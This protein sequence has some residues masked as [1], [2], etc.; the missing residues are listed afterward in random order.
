M[1][2]SFESLTRAEKVCYYNSMEENTLLINKK[3]GQNI[4]LYRK[5]SGLTQA[6]LAEKINYSDKSVSKWES[7]GGAPDIYVLMQLAEIFDVTVNDL[8]ASEQPKHVR[9]K[10]NLGLHLLIMGLSSGIVWLV[11]TFIFVILNMLPA[12]NGAVWTSF[13]F[14]L[15]VNS[16]TLLVLVSAWKYKRLNFVFVTATIW[17]SLLAVFCV[18][19]YIVGWAGTA[20]LVFLLGIPLQILEIFWAFF[21]YSL[22]KRKNKQ[23]KKE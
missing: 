18:L 23:D 2:N 22:F 17:T 5:R 19:Q 3:I 13:I 21:R 9:R 4:T 20:W 8:I 7:G 12:V 16:I 14:A 15:P 10:T 6:E 1:K 11:A